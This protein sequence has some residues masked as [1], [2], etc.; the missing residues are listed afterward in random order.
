MDLLAHLPALQVIVPMLSAPLI[1]LLQPR[2]LAWA[3]ATASAL[4]SFAIAITLTLAV[5]DG[6]TLEY[7]M[8]GWP[9]PFGIT[10]A[11][12]A[13]TA[14][15][16]LIVTGASAVAL[17]AAKPSIDQQIELERQPLFYSAWLLALSGLVGIVVAADAFN[18]FVFMEISSLASYILIA[19]GPDRRAL[20][21]VFKYLMM[22]TIGATFYLIGV[23]LIYMM[24]GTLN[25]AD[26][27]AR[28]GDVTDINPVLVAAGFITIGLAL[29]A[30]VFPLHVW[31]PN[32]YTHAPHMVTVFLAA[33]ATKVALYVLIRFD[34]M[35]FQAALD[36][37]QIQFALFA[38]PLAIL[39]I[40]VAS[41]VAMFEGHLKR[42]LASSSIAQI[43]Y[44]LL[45]ASFVS[46]AGL[47]ASAAHLFNHALAKGGLFLAVACLAY[48]YRDLR[49]S[50]L[51]GAS[52][53][54]PWTCAAFV[55]CGLSL[56]GVPG[57]AG[58]ISKWL[59]INAALGSGAWG[60]ALVAIIL[61]SSL[62][63]VVY[64]WRIVEALYFLPPKE[65][66][67]AVSE[68][69]MQLLIITGLVAVLN[70]YFGLF[71]QVPLDLANSAAVLLVEGTK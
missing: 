9:A 25:M 3:G 27:E 13:L 24:T 52:T 43:G 48:Q 21:A 47:S 61:L 8:G 51:G 53:R 59:L 38:M 30:A 56:I 55:V 44:I 57:T 58:F 67:V 31:V 22:G 26:M 7:A 50:Q 49:L 60:W 70:I 37:H 71:P 69:P 5:L 19:G 45:G 10:L 40:L 1:V 15:M 46:I 65:G 34:Y 66:E 11:V 42:L 62:M 12:D 63:A 14:L 35:I 54:M 64:V 16:L 18:I 6:Q 17:L 33:C 23:G 29:K 41:A 2:G 4:V 39:G 68:A 36:G 20:P 32:A 28:L